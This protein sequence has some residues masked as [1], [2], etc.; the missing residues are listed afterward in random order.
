LAPS[1]TE[2][3]FETENEVVKQRLH[4]F[5]SAQSC[6]DCLG[7][8]LRPEVLAVRIGR[9]N[10]AGLTSLCV[11]EARKYLAA[12]PFAGEKAIIAEPL[13]REIGER[14]RFLDDVGLGYLTLDR[15]S[16]SLS[17][18]EAQRIR[19]AGQVGGKLAGVTYVL[20]EPTIGLHQRDNA[21]LLDTLVALR[22]TGNTVLVVE[23][24][25]EVIR[26]ADWILDLGPGAGER[27]G[28]IVAQGAV[29]D[30]KRSDRSLTGRWL[31]GVSSIE[32]P[33]KRRP[34]NRSRRF[35]RIK[36][37]RE[38]NLKNINVDFPLSRFV[39]VTG[40]SGSGKS[41]LV[42]EILYKGLARQLQ[43]AHDKPGLSD[44]LIVAG[45]DLE[46]VV[47][48]DQSPIGRTPR[49]NPVTYTGVFDEIRRL[50]AELPEAKIRG[51][52]AG[53][54]SFNVKGGRCE[55]CQG[56]GCRMIEMHFIGD[57]AV[58]CEQCQ[59]RRFNRET[60]EVKFKGNSIA[61]VLRLSVNDARKLFQNH[62]KIDSGLTT[63]GDVGLGYVRLGQ[64]STTL[65]G[66]E[67]QRVKLAAELGKKTTGKTFYVLDE[68]TTGLHFHD[69]AKLLEV[70]T[71]LVEMGNTVTVIEHNLDV[72][73]MADWIIDL[74]PEGGEAGG[75]VVAEG[76]PEQVA[77][78]PQS[79][80]GQ[81][82][83]KVLTNQPA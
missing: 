29:E 12:Q 3:F 37:A 32:V 70:L 72:I 51:Y 30:I 75:R 61:D 9:L 52:N 13:L 7:A 17:G 41:S 79:L 14:L 27:G 40:V 24:D 45:D 8:R 19:L 54:F 68:P 33:K 64:S 63:L 67:A 31:S 42:N 78:C 10:I 62:P 35:I 46:K 28:E 15:Q 60:L 81:Y 36:G 53:R 18:G 76:T 57:V 47:N 23:H 49:S 39:C 43:G 65:S 6:P 34:V 22:D 16:G 48:V 55:H 66:G 77:A 5:M 26:R 58:E 69:I 44:Q 56:Q 71:R 25:E 80:T 11:A 21:R 83:R 4:E 74:G 2:R 38:N 82:L 1:L 50:F 73:K 20:D 59:G